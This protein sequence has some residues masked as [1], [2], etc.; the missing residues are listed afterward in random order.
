[1]QQT[2]QPSRPAKQPSMVD[3]VP[4][5]HREERRDAPIAPRADRERVRERE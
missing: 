4:S 1:M 3:V 2:R 5:S